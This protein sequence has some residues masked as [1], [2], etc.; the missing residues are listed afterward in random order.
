MRYFILL[1]VLLVI[2]CRENAQ[3]DD[4]VLPDG[5]MVELVDEELKSIVKGYIKQN[6]I[7]PE[8]T[9]ISLNIFSIGGREVVYLSHERE[10][11]FEISGYPSFLSSVDDHLI[12][13]YTSGARYLRTDIF[14]AIKKYSE[15]FNITYS[16]EENMIYH[17]EVWKLTRCPGSA[18]FIDK[19]A[20]TLRRD[21]VPCGYQYNS[22]LNRLDSMTME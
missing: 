16:H 18:F 9:Y 10:L 14:Q 20:P 2:S 5:F 13:I 19:G 3:T 11:Y 1:F 15:L 8:F 6:E 17:P 22:K 4:P 12:F 7:D 21:Y